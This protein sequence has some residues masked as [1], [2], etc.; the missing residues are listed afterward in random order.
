LILFFANVL[1]AAQ[2]IAAQ[3]QGAVRAVSNEFTQDPSPVAK[4]RQASQGSIVP[5]KIQVDGL[6]LSTA[7]RQHRLTDDQM[8][9]YLIAD[10]MTANPDSNITLSGNAQVRRNDVVL[11]GDRILY[12]R[13]TGEVD[14]L[15]HARLL[16]D[17][18]LAVAP[19]MHYNVETS[20][21]LFDSPEFWLASSGVAVADQAKIFNRSTMR[22]N[23]VKY[24]GCDCEEPAWYL[25]SQSIDLDF[26]ENEGV[27]HN[28]VLYFKDVPIFASPY[29]TFPVQAKRKSGFLPMT[30]ATSSRSGF[31]VTVPYYLNLAPNYDLTLLPREFTRRGLQLGG[32]ARYLGVG[33]S[34]TMQG[35]YLPNDRKEEERADRWLYSTQHNQN[36]GYGFHGNW[37][38]VRVSDD[39]YY[40]DFSTLGL[41]EAATVL[42]PRQGLL[43][44]DNQYWKSYVQV[45]TYQTLQ[46]PTAP[47]LPPYNKL[48]E[49]GLRGARYNW[50][51]VDVEFS[52]TVTRF[53]RP[54]LQGLVR[55]QFL[56]NGGSHYGPNGER[57]VMYPSVAYPIVRPGWF[58]TPKLGYHFTR[59]QDT[60]WFNSDPNS[61]GTLKY[62][63]ASSRALPILSVDS[64]M[65]FERETT[66][67]G[68]PSTHTLEPRLYFLH[69]PYRDQSF[70]PVYDTT[71]AD[72]SFSQAFE[73]NIFTGGWD[74]IAN[75][76]QMT[77]AVTT[78]WLDG[79]TGFERLSLS[80][81]QQIYFEKEKQEVMLPGEAPRKHGLSS[82]LVEVRAALTNTLKV[83]TGGQYDP[84]TQLWQQG[85]ATMHWLPQRL[86]TVSLSYRYQRDSVSKYQPQGQNQI[87][88]AL[89][90]PFSSRWFGVGRVDYS[91]HS[92]P[93]VGST[94]PDSRRITQAI[95]GLEY[96]SDRCWTGRIVFQ[97]YAVTAQEFNSAV[98]FQLELRGLGSLGTDV[99]RVFSQIPGYQ[100]GPPPAVLR[101]PFERYE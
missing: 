33:Y 32:E 93:V 46:E 86:T 96:R 10:V 8:S 12:H 70:L 43:G 49:L 75:A 6:R 20:S 60:D 90:W 51:G 26:D 45:Y 15:G 69:V 42:L 56:P 14:V 63:S 54:E 101:T 81:G 27:A 4:P 31:N 97:R 79:G 22:L 65:I 1:V 29:L 98:S 84:Y 7:L 40:R 17:G 73:E 3:E 95:A 87:S 55:Q 5:P 59:Y 83:A 66:L 25:K 18:L 2:V 39:N 34:G 35:T 52:G 9:N 67:F 91:L 82:S 77:A 21:A 71:L 19:A 57:L 74:R 47:L 61:L 88:L 53:V 16:R 44:W 99:T 28:G 13:T 38:I 48:P 76:T 100:S 68:K 58:I 24:S 41:N 62:P 89:Q 85:Y 64:G 72:F 78:N 37:N 36:F 11:K 80:V 92:G 30:Y 50:S 23:K 94:I